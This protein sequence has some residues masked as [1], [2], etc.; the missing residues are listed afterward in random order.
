MIIA[1]DRKLPGVFVS[2]LGKMRKPLTN[3]GGEYC[4]GSYL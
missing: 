3:G 1:P 2:N 4:R